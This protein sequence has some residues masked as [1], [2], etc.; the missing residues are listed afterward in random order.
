[1]AADFED[2][3]TSTIEHRLQD[4]ES[5][6]ARLMDATFVEPSPD[7]E[8]RMRAFERKLKT[9]QGAAVRKGA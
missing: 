5:A 3:H 4:I 6:I 7:R 2:N 9:G 1:M 8:T